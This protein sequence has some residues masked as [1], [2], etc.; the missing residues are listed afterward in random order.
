MTATDY[1]LE[2]RQR[3]LR[4]VS[5]DSNG[6][7]FR[8]LQ[9]TRSPAQPLLDI[10]ASAYD[11]N[12]DIQPDNYFEPF[13]DAILEGNFD[14]SEEQEDTLAVTLLEIIANSRRALTVIDDHSG[15]ESYSRE[16][17]IRYR[18]W[19]GDKGLVVHIQDEGPGFDHRRHVWQ[20]RETIRHRRHEDLLALDRAVRNPYRD[21][22]LDGVN[23]R[24]TYCLIRMT[25]AFR[26]NPAGNEVAFCVELSRDEHS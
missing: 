3:L 7:L 2:E 22:A 9:R 1:I 13:V 4:R 23:G 15:T 20:R 17:T 5:L 16:K 19:L 18:A 11:W 10:R 24:G 8:F 14:F 25:N 26:Y 12:F 21:I 6:A